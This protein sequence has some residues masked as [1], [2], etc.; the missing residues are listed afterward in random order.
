MNK[1]SNLLKSNPI[2][3]ISFIAAIITCFFVPPDV[4]YLNYFDL[5]TL[6]C[7]FCTLAVISALKNI[8]FFR[9]LAQKIIVVFHTLRSATLALVFI[10]YIGSMIIANDM[11]LLTFL[12]LGFFTLDKTGNRNH[13]AFTFT[14]QTLAANLGGM[15]TPFGN[16]QN[17]YLYSH[18]NI[19]DGDFF[20][21]MALPFLVSFILITACCLLV[22]NTPLTLQCP[23]DYGTSKTKTVIYLVL[24]AICILS[25]FRVIPYWSALILVIV[26]LAFI[27]YKALLQVDYPLLLTFCAFFVFSGNLSRIS[28]VKSI[29]ESLAGQNTLLFS[30]LSCQ[31]ISNVPTA[32]LLSRFDVNIFQL[33]VGVN[34][35]GV[36][37]LI[38]S[39]ASLITFREYNKRD[40]GSIKKYILI[41]S[42]LNFGFL[43]ILYLASYFMFNF[44]F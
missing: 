10:T 7:L 22:K 12:P 14:M 18:F 21:T 6:S 1:L 25:V 40:H 11:A 37:T 30:V 29:V 28:T 16:P 3:L 36:G 31:V 26:V 24:F 5:S 13:M 43:I 35:G 27:D 2:V 20:A 41:F 15:L 17:L 23:Q 39:L 42:G 34:I 4:E 38:S 8:A 33:L 44:S 19:S 9:T 32:V